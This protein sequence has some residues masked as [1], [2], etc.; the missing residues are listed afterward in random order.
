MREFL[1]YIVGIIEGIYVY[2]KGYGTGYI[3]EE[4][5]WRT[6]AVARVILFGNIFNITPVVPARRGIGINSIHYV[7]FTA[8]DENNKI[9]Y[10]SHGI[11]EIFLTQNF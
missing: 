10:K 6:A 1:V 9:W 11:G 2:L 5:E 3:A 7:L 4:R 8:H